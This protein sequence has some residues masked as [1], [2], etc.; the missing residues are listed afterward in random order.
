[1]NDK[2]NRGLLSCLIIIIIAS[3]TEGGDSVD[4]CGMWTWYSGN[5]NGNEKGPGKNSNVLNM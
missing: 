3:L 1:M 2:I 4:A 5:S